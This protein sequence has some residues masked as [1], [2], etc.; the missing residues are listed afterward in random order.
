MAAPRDADRS[1]TYY[2]GTTTEKAAASILKNGLDP[3]HTEI[4]YDGSGR[5]KSNFKPQE[6]RVYLTPSIPYAMVYGIGGDM[7]GHDCTRDI[8]TYGQYGFIFEFDGTS[9]DDI[10]PDEDSIGEFLCRWWGGSYYR[11][12]Y[13]EWFKKEAELKVMGQLDAVAMKHLTD[14]QIK[15][16]K[17]GDYEYWAKS[18]KKLLP[19]LSDEIKLK[20]I[21]LG[22]HVAHNGKIHPKKCWRFDRDDVINMKK[23][24][25][26]FFDYAKVWNG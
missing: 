19:L 23:D 6:H 5:S 12:N 9:F 26:N 2:H 13:S 11:E 21:D 7:A 1:K 24:G 16:V 8:K 25:S 22:A 20:L 3:L 18:G 10:S 17:S 14:A 15:R 4:K